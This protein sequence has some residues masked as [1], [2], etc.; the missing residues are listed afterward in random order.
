MRGKL[1]E[2]SFSDS[3][4][5][6]GFFCAYGAPFA[7]STRNRKLTQCFDDDTAKTANHKIQESIKD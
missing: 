1:F 6:N 2:A 3:E 4:V 5:E 7:V